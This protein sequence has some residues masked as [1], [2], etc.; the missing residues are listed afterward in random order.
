MP[1]AKAVEKAREW[2]KKFSKFMAQEPIEWLDGLLAAYAEH[3]LAGRWVSTKPPVNESILAEIEYI[4]RGCH[5]K[6]IIACYIE[7][8]DIKEINGDDVGWTS[9]VIRR[10]CYL[11]QPPSDDGKLLGPER[12][13]HE[14]HYC[15]IC[16][17]P[18]HERVLGKERVWVSEGG[19]MFCR[20]SGDRNSLIGHRPPPPEVKNR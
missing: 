4:Y 5:Q 13:P 6:E 15:D 14:C 16:S 2:R 8:D 20:T 19:S 18:I 12:D 7:G 3:V 17:L 10:W 1:D 11:P 9:E